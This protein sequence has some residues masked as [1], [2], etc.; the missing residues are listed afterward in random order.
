MESSGYCSLAEEFGKK[1]D[2]VAL[3]DGPN[4]HRFTLV[5]FPKGGKY[6]SLYGARISEFVLQCDMII[7]VPKLK[8]HSMAG[9][10]GAIKNL[11]GVMTQKGSMHPRGSIEILHKRLR[12]LY[13]LLRPRVKFCLMDGVVGSEYCEQAGVPVNTGLLL[14]DPDPWRLDCVAAEVMGIAPGGVPYLKY[15]QNDL[16]Q[17][18]PA[19]KRPR[20]Y[21]YERPLAWR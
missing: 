3:Q 9:I 21:R 7:D 17:A 19:M 13:F 20:S 16:G 6:M 11:M 2:V 5:R 1:V 12:D 4:F 15:I 10:T 18:F 8:V 14:S